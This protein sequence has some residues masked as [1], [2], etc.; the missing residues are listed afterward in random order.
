LRACS[1]L[2]PALA[3]LAG[4]LLVLT[5][6]LIPARAFSS[7]E[8]FLS[9]HPGRFELAPYLEILEDRDRSLTFERIS[10]PAFSRLYRP[11]DRSTLSLGQSGSDWWLRFRLR[12]VD[13]DPEAGDG[14]ETWS[15]AWW[16]LDLD[17]PIF[18]RADLYLPRVRR[19]EDGKDRILYTRLTGRDPGPERTTVFRLPED[20]LDGAYCYLRLRRA[21]NLSIRP[22]I[23]SAEQYHRHTLADFFSFGLIYGVLVALILFNLLLYSSLR[24][25]TY[26]FYVLYLASLLLG[27]MTIFGHFSLLTGLWSDKALLLLWLFLGSSFFWAAAFGRQFLA[28]RIN[29]PRLDLVLRI[30]QASAPLMI[31]L[32]LAGLHH[33]AEWTSNFL[34]LS[35]PLLGAATGLIC[36][37]RGYKP[38]RYFLLAWSLLLVGIV[39]FVLD[40]WLIP[41]TFFTAYTLPLGSAVEAVL[42]SFALADRIRDLRREREL[43][44]KSERRYQELSI[45]DGLTGLFNNRYFL[46]RLGSEVSHAH[47]MGQALSLVIMD[48]DNFKQYND[49]YGHPEGDEVLQRLARVVKDFA[50]E[51]DIPCRYGG[52]E[53]ILILP[54]TTADEAGIVAERIRRGMEAQTFRP[55]TW[56]KAKTTVSLGVAQLS[57]GQDAL[58]LLK[59]ADRSLY[60]AKSEGKNRT[61]VRG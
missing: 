7:P 43:L 15:G 24:D 48:V 49:T 33:Q 9:P 6:V 22:V 58:S 52:E 23:R 14:A 57:D 26:L 51:T 4:A 18:S 1:S 20:L 25:R 38:A 53:F 54:A 50:R 37:R 36:L 8:L 42:L 59:S 17:K 16:V 13:G 27:Q 56:S 40:G 32:G 29:A 46:S 61:V 39:L 19:T 2:P 34:G 47:I 3:L 28:T 31:L 55:T 41:R 44:K 5:L 12:R 11:N 30:Y 10:S 35:G 60:Q 45:T 21:I